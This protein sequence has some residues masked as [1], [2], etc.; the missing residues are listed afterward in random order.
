MD[1]FLE[2]LGLLKLFGLDKA[3]ENDD[4]IYILE[5]LKEDEDVNIT[6]QSTDEEVIYEIH[7][8][9]EDNG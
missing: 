1:C 2:K 7:I 5:R 6:T 4:L 3:E 8:S 9:R